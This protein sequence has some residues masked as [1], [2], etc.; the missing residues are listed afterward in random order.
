MLQQGEK[1]YMVR[2]ESVEGTVTLPGFKR[3]ACGFNMGT[4]IIGGFEA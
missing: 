4:I 1:E 3:E 2:R